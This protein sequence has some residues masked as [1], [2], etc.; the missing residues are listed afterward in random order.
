[1]YQTQLKEKS[2]IGFW[3][4]E[5]RFMNFLRFIATKEARLRAAGNID[6]ANRLKAAREYLSLC[7]YM[8]D[9]LT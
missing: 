3:Y 4:Y 8:K 6:R 2:T 7:Q 9:T 5:V 1:M